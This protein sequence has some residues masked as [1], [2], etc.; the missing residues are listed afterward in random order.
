MI[1]KLCVQNPR[2]KAVFLDYNLLTDETALAFADA[3]T[4]GSHLNELMLAGNM[5]SSKG[6]VK[7]AEVIG[8]STSSISVLT[9]TQRLDK[10]F[11]VDLSHNSLIGRQG[12][13][14]F[15][16]STSPIKMDLFKLT[17][18]ASADVPPSV[19]AQSLLSV[20]GSKRVTELEARKAQA[21]EPEIPE[22][23]KEAEPAPRSSSPGSS[24]GSKKSPLRKFSQRKAD[25]DD[26]SEED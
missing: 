13:S 7:L 17:M 19:A 18:H 25:D 11:T 26:S 16:S 23:V 3:I 21:P 8:V 14:S 1:A 24:R 4:D 22:D 15:F 20:S 2:I 5:I 6:A 12:F 10:V 9:S